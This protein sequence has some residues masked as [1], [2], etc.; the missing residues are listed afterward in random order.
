MPLRIT[1]D[2]H[3]PG[4]RSLLAMVAVGLAMAS[5]GCSV[6]GTAPGTARKARF[7]PEQLVKTDTDHFAE[8][9]Q[10]RIFISLR[11]LAEKLYRRNPREWR[12]GP[13]ASLEDA[14]AL[15]FEGDHGWRFE[16]LGYRRGID[17]LQIAFHLDFRGDRVHAFIVGLA[18]MV[19][20]AFG[21]RIGFYLLDE[22]DAQRLYNAARNVEIA[23]WKLGATRDAD[24]GPLLLSNEMGVVTNLSFEREFGKI[25]GILETLTDVT[26]AKTERTVVRVVQNM[27]TAVFLPLN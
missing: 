26:E 23:A 2:R 1:A 4:R 18:S 8:A 14:L 25:I 21:D 27:A 20:T 16:A 17:A 13:G 7:S 9:G 15:I 24:G 22:L 6:R 5:A 19:Q 10:R 12:K 3:D 11:A